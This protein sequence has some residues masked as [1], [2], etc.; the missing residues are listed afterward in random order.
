MKKLAII[1]CGEVGRL[2]ARAA[3]SHCEVVLCD[4]RPAPA[5]RELAAEL[6]VR[7]HES[8]GDWLGTVDRVWSCVTGDVAATVADHAGQY[9]PAGAVFVDLST[10]TP[11]DK[12]TSAQTLASRDVGYADA[13]IMG[14]I[15]LGGL[16]TALLVS[17][18]GAGIAVED[19]TAIG[20]PARALDDGRPGDAAAL[21]LLRTVLTKGLEAL[22]VEC[23]VAAE[24]QGV[25]E[26]LYRVLADI[27]AQGFTSFLE[28]IVRSHLIHAERRLHEVQRAVAQLEQ[29]QLPS[30]VLAG[31]QTR[32]SQTVRSLAAHPPAPDTSDSIESALAWL[33][34][35]SEDTVT[36]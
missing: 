6:G 1:G 30:S 15:G 12:R 24:Q 26:E 22:A 35:T 18:G 25:R 13:V 5:A 28:A 21:K 17:G 7:L 34:S 4:T 20:A 8:M 31:T 32:Y 9:L 10:A 3:A 14:A 23:L 33:L 29:A 11:Q 16:D 2:Y 27:D 36:A 19:F